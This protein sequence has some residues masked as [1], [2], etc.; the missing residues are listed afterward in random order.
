MR[1]VHKDCRFG[2]AEGVSTLYLRCGGQPR[3]HPATYG[4]NQVSI[5]YIEMLQND[6][7]D[8]NVP[9]FGT[10]SILYCTNN[11]RRG[12]GRAVGIV[13]ILYLKCGKTVGACIGGGC[14]FQFSI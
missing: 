8:T 9:V 7:L 1:H 10:V 5:L 2:G 12:A 3:S 14:L 13:S 6:A 11:I 4:C